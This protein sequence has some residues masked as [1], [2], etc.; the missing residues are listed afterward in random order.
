MA[1]NIEIP[2]VVRTLVNDFDEPQQFSDERLLQ[3]ICVAAKYVEFD[4]VL[5]RKYFVDVANPAMNPDPTENERDEIFISLVSLKAACIVDQ[6]VLR[7]KAAAEGIRASL[8]SA[9]L[10]IGNS[11]SG[12]LAILDKGSCASYDELVSHWDVKN[13]N[14][15]AAVLSPFVGN[16]FDPR[17]MLRNSYGHNYSREFYS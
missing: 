12:F 17:Y 4:V 13:A 3:I 9:S 10:T 1:W 2:I 16:S 11:L 14:A 6:G 5:D 8:G 7:S 15:V